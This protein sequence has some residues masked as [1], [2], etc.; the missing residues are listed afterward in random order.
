[1]WTVLDRLRF[2]RRECILSIVLLAACSDKSAADS[3]AGRT[4]EG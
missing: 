4:S 2:N 1:M 3:E